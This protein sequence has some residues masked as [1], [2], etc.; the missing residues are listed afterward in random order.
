VDV[1]PVVIGNAMLHL[2]DCRE[3]MAAMPADSVDA[4]VTDPPYHLTTGKK[5][6]TGPASVNLESPYGRARVTTGFMG[7]G[8]DGGNVAHDPAIWA[9]VL[10]VAKPGAYLLAFGGTRTYHRL[11]CAIED[12]GFEIRDQIGWAFGSGF[13]K[14]RNGS[15]GGTALKPAWEPIVMARK[16]LVGNVGENVQQFGTGGLNIDGCRV[17]VED[18]A[19]ARNFSGDRGHDGTRDDNATGST[20]MRMGGGKRP[21]REVAPMRDDVEYAGNALAGRVDGSL[22]TSKAVGETDLGRW[23]ANLIHDGSEEVLA[24]FPRAPGQQRSVGPEHGTKDSVNVFGDYGARETFNPRGDAGS[25]ARFFYCAKASRDDRNEDLHGMATKPLNWSSGEQSPG[26]FQSENT[27]REA[28]NHHPT[29]K[30][31]A[32]MRYLC[33][34]V[35]PPGGTVLDP[36]M[37]SGSTGK[38]T[39]REGFRFI[40][41]DL[42]PAYFAIACERIENAQRQQA[43]FV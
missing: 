43:M 22:Q 26:T 41:I 29:V 23:P 6:G 2:G 33:R 35:T 37:G 12:A 5:G 18:D 20:S 24:V 15:W 10:R 21:L 28:Q 7:M 31:T 30:P 11:A 36:F 13:P 3:A 32:L 34:L 9:E 42:D 27:N 4:I 40:G 16:P 39:E 19:Y 14:S 38:A 8:W 1:N 17:P 25:A